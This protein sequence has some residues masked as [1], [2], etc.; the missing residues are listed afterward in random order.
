MYGIGRG[1]WNVH[2][3]SQVK[4]ITIDIS[5]SCRKPHQAAYNIMCGWYCNCIVMN[6]ELITGITM[7]TAGPGP[8]C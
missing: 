1:Q 8:F 3:L 7:V 4:M 5:F 2:R 6:I